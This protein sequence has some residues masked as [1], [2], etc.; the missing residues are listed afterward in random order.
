[1]ESAVPWYV[2]IAVITACS[3]CPNSCLFSKPTHFSPRPIIVILFPSLSR[4]CYTRPERSHLL[5]TQP[6]YLLDFHSR[7]WMSHRFFH[8][9]FPNSYSRAAFMMNSAPFHSHFAVIIY[10]DDF[11]HDVCHLSSLTFSSL[12][13]PVLSPLD[14]QLDLLCNAQQVYIPSQSPMKELVFKACEPTY[15]A[16]C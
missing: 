2:F 15:F 1:M 6:P 4:V 12:I 10:F 8:W 14:I 11:C 3:S 5:I 16:A 13:T 7:S 9:G